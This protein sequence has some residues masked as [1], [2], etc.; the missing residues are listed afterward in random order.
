M[1]V[2]LT[3]CTLAAILLVGSMCLEMKRKPMHESYMKKCCI[4][5]MTGSFVMNMAKT[6][7]FL[8][9]HHLSRQNYSEE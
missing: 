9:E 6:V 3:Y 7:R 8:H 2:L 5:T 4:C 1:T